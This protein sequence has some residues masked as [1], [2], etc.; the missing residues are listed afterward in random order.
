MTATNHVLTGAL[1]AAAVHNPLIA[2]P[3]AFTSHFVLDAL[4]HFG[5]KWIKLDSVYFK[6]YLLGDMTTALLC[7]LLLLSLQPTH[8][9]VILAG[10]VLGAS[11]DLMWFHNFLAV[12]LHKPV[13][14]PGVIRRFHAR[15][16]W[17][18]RPLGAIVEVGW[19]LTMLTLLKLTLNK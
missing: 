6:T 13:V 4:P 8:V 14:V 7:L 17:Y 11:P 1:I 19:C 5:A 16:Q 12:N 18:E 9:W 10:G 15:I 3:A 2:L